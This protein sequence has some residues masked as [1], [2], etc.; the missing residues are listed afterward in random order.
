MLATFHHSMI[1]LAVITSLELAVIA[2]ILVR[3]HRNPA[4]R[5][6]WMVVVGVLPLLGMFAYL[7][8]GEVSIGRRRVQRLHAVIEQLP[9]FPRHSAGDTVDPVGGNP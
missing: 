9:P 2:R 1:A 3:P 8:L 7:L 6:A 4:S 5:I